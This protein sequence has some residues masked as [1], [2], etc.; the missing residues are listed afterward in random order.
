[1]LDV[2]AGN[3]L[4][5][6]SEREFDAPLAALLRAGGFTDV[7]ALHGQFE[8]GKDFIAKTD[9]PLTQY[10]LQSKAGDIGLPQW[11]AMRGQ[12]DLLRTNELAH[13]GF[14]RTLPRVGV[15]VLT[16][17]L[18]GGAPLEVQDYVRRADESGQTRFEVWDRERLIELMVRSPEA[19]LAGTAEG[20]LFE[21]LGHIDSHQASDA[22]VEHYA[23]RWI[24]EGGVAPS[25]M[26]EAAIVATRLR[27]ARRVDLACMVALGLLRAV[28]ASAHGIEPPA[29][30]T[31][32]QADLARQM[33]MAYAEQLWRQC[34]D[35]LLEPRT[36]IGQDTEGILLT[37]PVRC[38][39]LVEILGLYALALGEEDRAR[40]SQWICRF[41]R[42]QPGAAHPISDRWAISLIPPL[43]AV[44]RGAQAEREAHLRDV[45]RW[46]G[47][48]HDGENLG[49]APTGASPDDEADYLLG[50]ALEHVV[51]DRRRSSYLAT[52]VLDLAV[53]FELPELYDLAYNDI[54][55]VDVT[56]QVPLPNDDVDQYL[57]G[58]ADVPLDTSPRYAETWA[59]GEDSVMAAH[60]QEPPERYYLGRIGRAWDQLAINALLRDRHS[61]SA[62]RALDN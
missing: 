7:H 62:I 19:A 20:P 26:V 50:G 38:L 42:Q 48:R 52:V 55:A 11:T 46:L 47:D 21:L 18:I 35:D 54:A 2:V 6:V 30:E 39:R 29:D 53:A 36:L 34:T 4:D 25:A 56:P 24:R 44:G 8:F 17:R 23:A 28:W 22:E 59:K 43:V 12:I 13:P 58:N 3:F 45:V 40:V 1:L 10:A 57:G 33:F 14:D 49:L 5:S 31:V 9:G 27:E 60:Q 16:G 32:A 41:L 15:L 51:R 37:Y 61:M